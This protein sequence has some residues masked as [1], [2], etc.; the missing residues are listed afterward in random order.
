MNYNKQSTAAPYSGDDGNRVVFIDRATVTA[1]L[2]T[3]DK[4]RPVLIPAGTRVDQVTI[5]NGELDTGT[6]TL[7][8]SIGFEHADGSSGASATAVAAIGANGLVAAGEATYNLLPPVTLE[9]DAYLVITP[10]VNANAMAAP[11]YVYC[12]VLGEN[13]GAK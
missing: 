11:A 1:A 8:A 5:K 2:T 6:D 7:T 4:V 3:A 9:K 10:A 12:R 13:L